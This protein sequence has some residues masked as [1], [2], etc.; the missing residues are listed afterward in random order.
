LPE[1]RGKS[2]LT[3]R[4]IGWVTALLAL[5]TAFLTVI[6]VR[7]T[8][9]WYG[10]PLL[11]VT[12][13]VIVGLCLVGWRLPREFAWRRAG[14]PT[15]SRL[16]FFLIGCF[17]Y[18]ALVIEA[19]AGV[20]AAVPAVLTFAVLVGTTVGF[21]FWVLRH[22]GTERHERHVL[23]FGAGLLVLGM[24][25]GVLFSFP[26]EIVVVADAAVIVFF[27]W[28]DRELAA[29]ELAPAPVPGHVIGTSDSH[30]DPPLSALER[31]SIRT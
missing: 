25:L 2:L 8:G 18:P 4:Q 14:A 31:P 11:A 21:W 27:R 5:D 26:W 9:Y 28:L 30:G 19:E 22:V 10:F 6:V 13:A 23:A 24:V 1:T 20:S 12:V 15:V 17:A 16:Q 29:R 7:S 3:G